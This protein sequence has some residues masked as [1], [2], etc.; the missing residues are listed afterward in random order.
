MFKDRWLDVREADVELPDGRR[1]THKVIHAPP[2]AG[3]VVLNNDAEV[4]LLW[5]HRFITD[6]WTYEIPIGKVD[7]GEEPADAARREC[8]EETGWEPMS[9]SPLLVVQPSN[10]IM[11]SRHH[12]F[13][14][15]SAR[16]V[17][18]PEGIEAERVEWV[19][20]STIVAL[21]AEHKVVGATTV[22]A[23]LYAAARV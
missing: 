19:P 10:G 6:T 8:I 7:P 14:A 9:L 11:T 18:A 23:L 12:V 13:S 20:L 22:A 15:T 3:A 4:L 16:Q 17:A 1:L 5:R 2:S 21:I